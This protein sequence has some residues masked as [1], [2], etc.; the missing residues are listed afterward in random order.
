[1]LNPNES[2]WSFLLV[3]LS[4]CVSALF[5]LGRALTTRAEG[6]RHFAQRASEHA[7]PRNPEPRRTKIAEGE[8]AV[9]EPANLGTAGPFG[10]EVYNFRETWTMW[11]T[12]TGGYEVEGKR[13]FKAPE[14]TPHDNRFLVRLS[15]DLTV[16][17]MTEFAKLR[18]SPNSG[19]LSCKFLPSELHCS[20]GG[21]AP[22]PEV[23]L[24][25]PVQHPFGLFWPIAAFSL[26][27]ITRAAERDPH[28]ETEVEPAKIEQPNEDN[29]VEVTIL[30][31]QLR[32]LGDERIDLVGEKWSAYKFSL[33]LALQPGLLICVS[34][35]GL[36]LSV[37]VEHG[38]KDWP[39]EEMKL[40]RFHKWA[41]F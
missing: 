2:S 8:Y 20:A 25:T 4:L 12:G 19:P 35:K 38:H 23:E 22:T 15:R 11:R 7:N 5:V 39:K 13:Q 10:E 1:M 6:G 29:P 14:D 30:G 27:G 40:V 28:R 21:G 34:R 26:S 31:G 37:T 3:S 16:I 41:D 24:H 18:W 17:D 33:K 32:Y 9:I 36:L